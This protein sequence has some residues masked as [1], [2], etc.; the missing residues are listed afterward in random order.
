MSA[1]PPTFISANTNV[2]SNTLGPRRLR[3]KKNNNPRDQK[4]AQ[5]AQSLVA[6]QANRSRRLMYSDQYSSTSATT[7]VTFVDLTNIP[8]GATQSERV[9]DTVFLVRVECH[10]IC[11]YSFASSVFAQDVYDNFRLCLFIYN[12]N[13][14]STVPS[15]AQI[16]QSTGS[17]GVLSPHTFEDSQFVR[18]LRSE[19]VSCNGFYDS[20]TS[21]AFPT[22]ESV[23]VLSFTVP[24]SSTVKFNLGA[25]SGTGKL[26][27]C[28]Y[29]DSGATPHP[30]ITFMF[31][32]YY[33]QSE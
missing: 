15:S 30:S 2:R 8:Q 28:Y 18:I 12:F 11:N 21:V 17:F 22:S 20:A 6:R 7:T 19:V 29:S 9:S 16:F 1:P 3:K 24:L 26:Y 31:R 25:T 13:T 10:I 4:I 33:T 23:K 32:T 27:F 5:V 14:G